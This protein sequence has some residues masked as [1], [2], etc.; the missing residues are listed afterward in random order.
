MEVRTRYTG[1]HDG[2]PLPL[3]FCFPLQTKAVN[4]ATFFLFFST[5]KFTAATVLA[6]AASASAFAPVQQAKV[7][8]M[9]E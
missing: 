7:R 1:L 3:S 2:S 6:L 5:M 9:L 4:I 8:T